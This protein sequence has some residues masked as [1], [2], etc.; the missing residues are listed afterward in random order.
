MD[1]AHKY[2][3][4]EDV[5]CCASGGQLEVLK[6]LRENGCSWDRGYCLNLS[7][8]EVRDWIEQQG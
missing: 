4:Q 3:G 1:Q 6:Y 7:Y 8:G 5:Q 2:M